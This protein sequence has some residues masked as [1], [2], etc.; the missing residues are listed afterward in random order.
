M[1]KEVNKTV[2]M[3]NKGKVIL[4]PTDTVWGIGCDA[5]NHNA[6][7]K[8][9]SIKRRVESKSL[10][11]LVDT[12]D[13]IRKYVATIPEIAF[14]LEKSIDSPLTIIYPN[15]KNLARNVIASDNSIAIRVTSDEFCKRVI[16]KFGKPIVSSSA[17]ITGQPNPIMFNMISQAVLDRVDYVVSLFQ[18]QMRE[19]KP[20]RIIKL[21]ENGEFSVIRP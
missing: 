4:Y 10:I 18:D 9:Y 17:N 3:L 11:I 7:K 6:V 14:D 15:A 13:M 1:E 12:F 21:E 19:T 8:I 16:N 2:D 5:T 20:S